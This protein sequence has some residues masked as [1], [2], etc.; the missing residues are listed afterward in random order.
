MVGG[1][2]AWG[3]ASLGV[4]GLDRMLLG[5]ISLC[6]GWIAFVAAAP[7]CL[8]EWYS[9]DRKQPAS[10]TVGFLAGVLIRLASTVALMAVCSYQVPAAREQ[11][12]GTILVWYVYLTTVDVVALAML[13]PGQDRVGLTRSQTA[14]TSVQ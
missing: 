7:G 14:R 2:L 8:I 5:I 13:L 1:C 4:L 3:L 11:I 12:A 9:L 6:S 10:I